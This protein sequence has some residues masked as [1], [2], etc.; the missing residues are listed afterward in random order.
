MSVHSWG[1][2]TCRFATYL[3]QKLSFMGVSTCRFASCLQHKLSFVG[4]SSTCR[5]AMYLQHK[6]SFMGVF[7][8][9]ICHVSATQAFIHGGLPLAGLP[10]ICNI[11]FHSWG[12][13]ICRFATYLQH[14][15][16]F[17]GGLPLEGLPCT[18]QHKLSFMEDFHLQVCHV[19]A[20]QAFIH[21]GSSSCR[22]ATYLQHK[23]SFMGVFHLQVCH[24]SATKA[25]I[26]GGLPIAG[27]LRICKKAFIHGAPPLPGLP[28]ICNTSI[29]SGATSTCRFA[30]YLQH[31]LSFMGVFHLQVCHV[32]AI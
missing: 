23:L 5:F 8:L 26:H 29:H 9:Q 21:G 16:S 17:M 12:S 15:L 4:G 18:L 6:L 31:K 7:P 27:L 28:H 25:F 14:K 20:A 10:R 11:S 19:S 32:S 2:S 13:P 22:F 24:V 3:Q 1:S 30:T